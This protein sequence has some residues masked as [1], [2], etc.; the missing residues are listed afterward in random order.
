MSFISRLFQGGGDSG[1]GRVDGPG[2]RKLVADGAFLLDVRTPVEFREAHV[3]DAINIPVSELGA[4]ISEV[5]TDR[6]VVVYC[7]SG[8]RSARAAGI[9]AHAGYSSVPD[10]GP[11]SAW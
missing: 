11:M 2:A 8:G 5:P 4:R 6:D 3:P 7:R 10:L 1:G 9:L